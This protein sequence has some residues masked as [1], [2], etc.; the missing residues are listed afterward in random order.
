M[1]PA[2]ALLAAACLVSCG[3]PGHVEVPGK[4]WDGT[5]I[6]RPEWQRIEERFR[7]AS[8]PRPAFGLLSEIDRS[9]IEG[10]M[11]SPFINSSRSF[12][13]LNSDIGRHHRAIGLL[14]D[15][16]IPADG[17]HLAAILCG[18]APDPYRLRILSVEVLGVLPEHEDRMGH[19]FT[20]IFR[21]N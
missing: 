1:K 16:D 15:R 11:T 17:S 4:P 14:L 2:F 12:T 10:N 13:I 20:V 5:A 6:P 21:S 8:Y 9:T 3:H 7:K 19:H 18:E